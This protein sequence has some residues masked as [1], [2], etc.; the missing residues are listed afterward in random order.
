MVPWNM[1]SMP[2]S[3]IF[4]DPALLAVGSA[5]SNSELDASV[6]KAIAFCPH[7]FAVPHD[8]A[9][10]SGVACRLGSARVLLKENGLIE[11]GGPVPWRH[12]EPE[13]SVRPELERRREPE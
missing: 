12:E 10:R 4:R 2:P 3:P 1:A 13:G 11:N 9:R 7:R 8:G 6:V 5:D